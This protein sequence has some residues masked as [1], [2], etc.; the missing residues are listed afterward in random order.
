M[1][2]WCGLNRSNYF[3]VKDVEAFKAF[4]GRCC[5][6]R[7]V[8]NEN[9]A[10]QRYAV[11]NDDGEGWPDVLYNEDEDGNESETEIDFCAELAKHLDND[12]AVLM[13]AGFEGARYASGD[14][15]AINCVGETC[16]VSLTDIYAKA[17]AQ[18]GIQPTAAEY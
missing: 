5:N 13:S 7:L 12:V 9:A 17:L 4:V 11:I 8:D 16:E 1:T 14:A 18:F 3:K 15:F 10:D 6:L 2:N